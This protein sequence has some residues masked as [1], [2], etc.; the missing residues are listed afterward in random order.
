MRHRNT[1]RE[2]ILERFGQLL[3]RLLYLG[4][5]LVVVLSVIA[6]LRGN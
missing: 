6:F 3:D 4:I 2:L 5:A 1:Q